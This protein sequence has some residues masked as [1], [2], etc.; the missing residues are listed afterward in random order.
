MRFLV[1]SDVHADPVSLERVLDHASGERW[2][3]AVFLGD[4]VGYGERA[5]EAVDLVRSLQRRTALRGNHEEMLEVVRRGDRPN[6]SRAIVDTLARN[7]SEL[8]PEDLSFLDNLQSVHLDD[9]WGAVHGALRE[10]F[11]YLISVP[12]A[13]S[14]GSH[15]KR[16]IYFVG[17][18]HV[19]AAYLQEPGGNWTLRPFGPSGGRVKLPAGGRAFLN[20]GS[21]SLPRDGPA[22]PS[23]AIFDEEEREFRVH[24]L[25]RG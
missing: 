18:T 8:S 16:D 4:L 3:E 17:H 25:A 24:R 15:M 19:P 7:L 23:Y 1:F 21:V 10:P 20:P 12:L 5:G 2:D 6:A 13:R 9:S 11:E 22:G 14:N